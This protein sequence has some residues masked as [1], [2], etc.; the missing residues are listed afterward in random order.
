MRSRVRNVTSELLS[1]NW[2]EVR[3]HSFELQRRDGSWQHQIRETYD[4]GHGAAVLLYNLDKRT[5]ILTRQFRFPAYY[6]G[7]ANPWLVEAPAGKLD[8]D[9]PLT[10]AKKEAEEETGYRIA[11]LTFVGAPYMSPGS[12]TERLYLYVGEYHANER[13]S[14][15]GGLEDEGEDIE[16]LELPFTDAMA[17]LDRGEIADGKT[18]ILLQY[19]ALKG[20]L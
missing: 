6:M 10:C 15:G 7:D 12:V 1:D 11:D 5:I 3:K 18:I 19:V 8:G 17:M 2:G 16:T 9:D 14:E 20:L 4:R 13:I